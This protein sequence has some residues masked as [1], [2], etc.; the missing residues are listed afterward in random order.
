MHKNDWTHKEVKLTDIRRI[1]NLYVMTIDDATVTSPLLVSEKIFNERLEMYFLKSFVDVTRA[2][3]LGVNWNMYI[4]K[5]YYVKI[6]ADEEIKKFEV[7]PNKFYVS[8]LEISGPL[9]SFQSASKQFQSLNQQKD[10]I[11]K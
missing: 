4:T 5:G 3:I 6:G 1:A 8:F 7:D 11:K 2:E 10:E 9:A